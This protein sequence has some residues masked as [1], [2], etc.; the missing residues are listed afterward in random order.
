MKPI[1]CIYTENERNSL[2]LKL[3]ME[4]EFTKMVS[5]PARLV[6]DCRNG[7]SLSYGIFRALEVGYHHIQTNCTTTWGIPNNDAHS[8]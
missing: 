6:T 8:G 5:F 1:E 7:L 3:I 4:V 2:R